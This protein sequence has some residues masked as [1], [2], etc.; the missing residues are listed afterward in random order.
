MRGGPEPAWFYRAG[1][2]PVETLGWGQQR[3]DRI[4][5]QKSKGDISPALE[6]QSPNAKRSARA[7]ARPT[8]A[9]WLLIRGARA[10]LERL[11][12]AITFFLDV[13]AAAIGPQFGTGTRVFGRAQADADFVESGSQ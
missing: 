12:M 1:T 5:Q 10:A 9:A 8:L 11:R 4:P 3:T 2:V 7:A 6:L 13:D